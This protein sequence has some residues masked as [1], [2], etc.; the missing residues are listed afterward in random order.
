MRGPLTAAALA[1]AALAVLLVRPAL[2]SGR[3]PVAQRNWERERPGQP[4]NELTLKE[5]Q[6]TRGGVVAAVLGPIEGPAPASV[7]NKG[8]EAAKTW[9]H[10]V[11]DNS[12]PRFLIS[13]LCG[14]SLGTDLPERF[15]LTG[16][17]LLAPSFEAQAIMSTGHQQSF[18]LLVSGSD[19][20]SGMSNFGQLLDGA[21]DDFQRRYAGGSSVPFG[22][23]YT[24]LS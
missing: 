1:L 2:V 24:N 16:D 11:R 3:P 19:P 20:G 8:S 23:I 13:K 6:P 10:R 22:P 4:H 12:N 18:G 7:N 15:K 5:Q 9:T 14:P 17:G 21:F